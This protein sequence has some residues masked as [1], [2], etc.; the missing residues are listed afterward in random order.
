MPKHSRSRL[1]KA[2]APALVKYSASISYDKR[3][4]PYDVAGSIAHARMLGRQ[5]IIAKAEAERLIAGLKKIEGELA[6]GTFAFHEELEDIHI[7]VE[8]RLAEIVGAVAGKLHTARSRNDQVALDVRLYVKDAVAKTVAALRGLQ[9]AVVAQAEANQKTVMPG[10]THL[11]HGQP[12]LLAHHL[13]AYFEMLERDVARFEDCL[14]RVD[15]MPLG[16]GAVAGSP[17]ALDREGV[18]KELGF[19]AIS[20]NSID[21]VSDRDFVV[22]YEAA[23]S[24]AMM[25]CSRLAEELVLWSSSE[26]GFIEFDDAYATGSSL[27]P[28]KK[29][30]DVAELARGKTGRV[31][32]HLIASLTLLKGLPLSYNRDLQEDKEGLFDTVD[33]LLS[34]VGVLAEAVG[35]LRFQP[36]RMRGAAA[37]GYVLAT[38]FADYLVKKGMPFR[39]AHGV[40]GELVQYAIEQRK[41]LPALSL[42]ELQ[43]FS[44][45]FKAD[46]ATIN[47]D[48]SIASRTL[49]G[50]T[51]PT[52]VAAA[53]KQAQKVLRDG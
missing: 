48:S 5:G 25:H 50:G 15:V 32:G 16:S 45:Q 18:A 19:S 34:T 22:E 21:A 38:D 24:L 43:L 36:E 33:T 8:A 14:K 39:E 46:V 11:Q 52:A 31:Y 53:L 27:M 10:Y 3:L 6:K 12:V 7:N 4:A 47:L 17:Y 37:D 49:P 23:A 35:T 1:K 28:Q 26:F 30:P 40:V 42:K 20:A 9:T 41:D 44:P 51:A 29:N 2:M 13:L